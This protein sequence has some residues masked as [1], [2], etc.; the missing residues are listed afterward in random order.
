MLCVDHIDHAS[1]EEHAQLRQ[2]R[3]VGDQRVA[4]QAA[5]ELQI[6][7][8][9]E[10]VVLEGPRRSAGDGR[11]AVIF[12]P[13]APRPAAATR[14]AS[15]DRVLRRGRP[16]LAQVLAQL[17][18][19]GGQQLELGR[20]EHAA[21]TEIGRGAGQDA[22]AMSVAIP[23]GARVIFGR[24]ELLTDRT[25]SYCPGC[26]HG[27]VHRLIAEVLGELGFASFIKTSGS[28]GLH[29]FVPSATAAPTN[30]YAAI[31]KD[32]QGFDILAGR[33]ASLSATSASTDTSPGYASTASSILGV[34]TAILNYP[35][36]T[37]DVATS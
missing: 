33:G 34:F 18:R 32:A 5:L 16:V 2:I 30:T 31:L 25:N 11:H 36:I 21:Q 20:G 1:V 27:V 8:E 15:G 14:R 24:P 6:R 3:S 9:V 4:R 23:E 22:R 19:Q 28:R 35:F 12:A 13:A 37:P 10:H 26:G 29:A 7:E 17:G